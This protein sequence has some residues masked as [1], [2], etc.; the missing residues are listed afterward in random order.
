MSSLPLEKTSEP[1]LLPLGS[2]LALPSSSLQDLD[3]F[4]LSQVHDL[5]FPSHG[6]VSI[7][8]QKLKFIQY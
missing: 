5:Q 4:S 1:L 7:Y 2:H 3:P 8:T 6:K